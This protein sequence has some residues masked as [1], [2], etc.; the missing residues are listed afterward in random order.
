MSDFIFISKEAATENYFASQDITRI[1]EEDEMYFDE[2]SADFAHD[3]ITTYFEGV[4]VP[5]FGIPA[6]FNWRVYRGMVKALEG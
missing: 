1:D 5:F 6:S 2:Y 4:D 3:A